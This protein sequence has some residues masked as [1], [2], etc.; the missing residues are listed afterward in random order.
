M[1][2]FSLCAL[3]NEVTVETSSRGNA[4]LS[5][6][7]YVFNLV[8]GFAL[9]E[10]LFDVWITVRDEV[11]L[12]NPAVQTTHLAAATMGPSCV[13]VPR[14]DLQRQVTPAKALTQNRCSNKCLRNANS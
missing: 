12:A 8:S 1:Q 2:H 13:G 14:L 7:T 4:H 3:E 10:P 11:R 5:V 6:Q 9:L